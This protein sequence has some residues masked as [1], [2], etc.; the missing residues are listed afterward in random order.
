MYITEMFRIINSLQSSCSYIYGQIEVKLAL[1]RF[2]AELLLMLKSDHKNYLDEMVSQFDSSRYFDENEVFTKEELR[3]YGSL[4]FVEMGLVFKGL[5]LD[6][7]QAHRSPIDSVEDN[8]NQK[9]DI[10]TCLCV[11]LA[12]SMSA[13]TIAIE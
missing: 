13:K 12:S 1:S 9:I 11:L 3:T 6:R 7:N 2:I 8:E 4:I 10:S 5:Y